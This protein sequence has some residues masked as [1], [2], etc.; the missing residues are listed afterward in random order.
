MKSDMIIEIVS[1]MDGVHQ[2]VSTKDGYEEVVENFEVVGLSGQDRI[3]QIERSM[4]DVI[5]WLN[6]SDTKLNLKHK[7]DI[8]NLTRTLNPKDLIDWIGELEDYFEL[9]DIGDPLKVRLA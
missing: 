8:S 9:E 4:Q 7:K 5:G 2:H 6:W 1:V 3:D